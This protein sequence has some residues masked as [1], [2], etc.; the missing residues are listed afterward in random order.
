MTSISLYKRK[1]ERRASLPLLIFVK[2]LFIY[3]EL[4]FGHYHRTMLLKTFSVWKKLYLAR[5]RWNNQYNQLLEK[6]K[7]RKAK[8]F[9]TKLKSRCVTS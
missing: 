2:K 1:K 6:Q 8:H 4:A 5:K 9:L 7:L 3:I